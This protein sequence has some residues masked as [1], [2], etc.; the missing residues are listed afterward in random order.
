MKR[1]TIGIFASG[2]F[3]GAGVL[4]GSA[5]AQYYGGIDFMRAAGVSFGATLAPTF[6]ATST[7]LDDR[8]MRYG[9]KLDV[10][11]TSSFSLVGNYLQVDRRNNL[12]LSIGESHNEVATSR[13]YGLD[14]VGKVSVFNRLVLSGSAGVARM[15]GDTPF[16]VTAPGLF[17]NPA[18]R[19]L[20][21]GK[22]G[23]G[24]Q[25]NFS[26]G[27]GLRFEADRYRALS[28]ASGFHGT[29]SGDLDADSFSFG[30]LLKF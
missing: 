9:F 2:I 14:L 8:R 27:L 12:F 28:G 7:A 25:Y 15:R 24:V 1:K 5:Q 22:V 26:N 4:C 13:Q 30:V 6:D 20:S 29:N 10:P 17:P 23:V 19:A 18:A 11:L 3:A 16:G 21:A